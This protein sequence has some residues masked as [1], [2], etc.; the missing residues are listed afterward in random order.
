MLRP[1][2]LTLKV[3]ASAGTVVDNRPKG[4]R[5]QIAKNKVV[6][7]EYTLTGSD[8]TV[9]D[10]SDGQEPLAYIQGI[11][12]IIPGLE[13]ALEG[14]TAGYQRQVTVQPENAYGVRDDSLMQT[15]S[16][17][18]FEGVDDLEV[19]MQF[20][21]KDDEG[22]QIVTVV[23][24]EDETVTVDGNHPLAGEILNFNVNVVDVRD[25]TPEELEHGHVHGLG[26]HHH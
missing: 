17:E 7:M 5:M 21:A 19:G 24:L 20:E 14:K 26:G 13:V 11:G 4:L 1:A 25:A 2:I 23:K 18:Q 6:V 3:A 8:G 9:L 10:T 22:E 16:R 15:I 12:S